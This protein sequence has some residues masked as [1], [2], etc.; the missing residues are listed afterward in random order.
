[1]MQKLI[2]VGNSKALTISTQI[3]KQ[4]GDVEMAKVKFEPSKK[5]MI[6][7]FNPQE[8]V[9]EVIDQEVYEVAKNLLKRYGKA[10]SELAK[11]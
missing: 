4:V 9:D 2:T 5:R 10:F 8:V 1:M 11:K 6:V 7:D 3:L